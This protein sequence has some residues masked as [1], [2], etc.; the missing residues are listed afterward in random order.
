MPEQEPV[1][2]ATL[3]SGAAIELFNIELQKALDNIVDENTPPTALR[4][5]WLKVKIKPEE[6]RNYGKVEITAGAKLAPINSF[7]TNFFIG[8][9]QGK[10][11]AKEDHRK[12]PKLFEEPK[13]ATIPR[14]ENHA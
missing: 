8:K 6:D 7:S 5:V 12:Q 3:G 14:E 11:I 1:T 4:E 13:L 2:L 10:G 9:K